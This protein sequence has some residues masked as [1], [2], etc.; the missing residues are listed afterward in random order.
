M[1]LLDDDVPNE[2][3]IP[4]QFIPSNPSK[5]ATSKNPVLSANSSHPTVLPV[6]DLLS[7]DVSFT[8]KHL[9]LSSTLSTAKAAATTT[10]TETNPN[11][12][13]SNSSSLVPNISSHTSNSDIRPISTSSNKPPETSSV[14][15]TFIGRDILPLK[16]DNTSLEN[17]NTKVNIINTTITTTTATTTTD[18]ITNTTAHSFSSSPTKS[19]FFFSVSSGSG[20]PVRHGDNARNDNN[21]EHRELSS[22]ELNRGNVTSFPISSTTHD[23]FAD[24]ADFTGSSATPSPVKSG[25]NGSDNIIKSSQNISNINNGMQTDSKHINNK[26]DNDEF[27]EFSDFSGSESAQSPVNLID[28]N[29][30]KS[31]SVPSPINSNLSTLNPSQS[32]EKQPSS[33]T[34][35]TSP[36][37]VNIDKS[38]L[39]VQES[40]STTIPSLNDTFNTPE[41]IAPSSSS[42]SPKLNPDLKNGS[43]ETQDNNTSSSPAHPAPPTNVISNESNTN[44]FGEFDDFND[45]NGSTTVNVLETIPSTVSSAAI[46]QDSNEFG[47]FEVVSAPAA[48]VPPPSTSTTS[49]S[50]SLPCSSVPVSSTNDDFDDFTSF[51]SNNSKSN[52]SAPPTDEFSGFDQGNIPGAEE[53]ERLTRT[54]VREKK[55]N[56]LLHLFFLK[57]YFDL[58]T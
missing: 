41:Q 52:T 20:S 24:F 42:L 51:A 19:D 39:A 8:S 47:E 49:T 44:D 25:G 57:F 26:N 6:P 2:L 13:P 17:S 28:T 50:V 7:N 18:T 34:S 16:Q 12:S 54:T 53:M 9:P 22:L 46:P 38:D 14:N 35:Q 4:S 40:T 43:V 3:S 33:S 29:Y 21:M 27:G 30:E 45:F 1:S 11:K 56:S 15:N 23:D 58:I 31:S 48:S 36:Q 5:S 10:T 32:Y 37:H 55:N